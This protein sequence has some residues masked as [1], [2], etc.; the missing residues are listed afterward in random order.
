MRILF[1]LTLDDVWIAAKLTSRM[2]SII[3]SMELFL[4]IASSMIHCTMSFYGRDDG[5]PMCEASTYRNPY[6]L[7]S[8]AISKLFK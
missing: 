8:P 2:R 3:E 1:I 7:L 5:E 6:R 4:G